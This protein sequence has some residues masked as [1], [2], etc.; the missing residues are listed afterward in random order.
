MERSD[1]QP[2]QLAR[3]VVL[4]AQGHAELFEHLRRAFSGDAK[5]QVVLDR[6][7][8]G[9]RTPEW[10]KQQLRKDGVVLIRVEQNVSPPPT[11]HPDS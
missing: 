6:R 3:W 1:S 11:E 10:V 5:V 8:N 4:V 9:S 7:A 2:A